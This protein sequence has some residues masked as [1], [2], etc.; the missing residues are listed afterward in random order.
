MADHDRYHPAA[1]E[2]LAAFG[3]DDH[4]VELVTIGENV[5]FRAYRPGGPDSFVLRLHRPGYHSLA[6]L[7]SERL[8]LAALASAGV[9][10]PE[11]AAGP[12]GQFFVPVTVSPGDVRHAGLTRWR[13]GRILADPQASTDVES[14]VT[15]QFT[16]LGTLMARM[17]TQAT[18]WSPPPGFTRQ[19]LDADGLVGEAPF[20]GRFWEAGDLTPAQAAALSDARSVALGH[21][22]AYGEPADRFSMIHADLHLGNL[23]VDPTGALSV[24][25]F[26]DAGYGWHQYDMAV[27]LLHIWDAPDAGAARAAFFDAYR[28]A[29]PITDEELAWVPFFETVRL[30]A[31]IG[32]KDQRP[33]VRWPEGRFNGLVEQALDRVDDLRMG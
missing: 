8:W 10:V 4:S 2:A 11:P 31:L 30:M 24:I 13:D 32:W 16:Q 21:L 15:D 22:R 28:T 26:D 14:S 6:E 5:T 17:H 7:D 23:L 20:W 33:E 29:R 3:I 25:D 12:D 1:V 27:A 19:R 9:S 18:A